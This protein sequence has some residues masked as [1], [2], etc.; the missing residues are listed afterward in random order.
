MREDVRQDT[1]FKVTIEQIGRLERALLAMRESSTGP[2]D[3]L[4]TI[5]A[6]Q[7][8][9]IVR[10]RSE[11]DAALGFAKEARGIGSPSKTPTSSLARRQPG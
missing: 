1:N 6:I 5:A 3:T 4:D 7:Y 11:L 9:E 8:Q 10:L 2:P